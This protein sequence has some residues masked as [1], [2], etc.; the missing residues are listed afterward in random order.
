MGGNILIPKT[1]LNEGGF[2]I[3]EKVLAQKLKSKISWPLV[4]INKISQQLIH[5]LCYTLDVLQQTIFK[6]SKMIPIGTI[7]Q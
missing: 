1:L 4:L 6:L 7:N 5:R 3:Y 2:E